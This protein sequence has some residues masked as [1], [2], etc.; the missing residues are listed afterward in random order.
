MKPSKPTILV[1]DDDK[2]NLDLIK[3]VFESEGY[4]V[5]A[6][7]SLDDCL[8][9]VSQKRFAAIILDNR[10]GDRS[11]LEVCKEIHWFNSNTPII[12]YSG[13]ARQSEIEKALKECGSAY[14]IKPLGFDSLTET[15]DNL[16]QE[17]QT[18]NV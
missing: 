13:E 3:F 5:T 12:F 2:D 10:F 18:A 1:V 7:D 17:A 9:Q 8:T 16:I 15:V 4:E 6:C 14:L 11:S